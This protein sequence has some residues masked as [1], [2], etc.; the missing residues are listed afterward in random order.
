MKWRGLVRRTKTGRK[1]K[2]K[3]KK[4]EICSGVHMVKE[5]VIKVIRCYIG[6]KSFKKRGISN[7]MDGTDKWLS[8]TD[9]RFLSVKKVP[10]IHQKYPQKTK[11]KNQKQ[12]IVHYC[13]IR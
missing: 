11:T 6:T 9:I 13:S 12:T 8:L 1:E 4:T 3:R 5:F 7:A 2:E 10:L